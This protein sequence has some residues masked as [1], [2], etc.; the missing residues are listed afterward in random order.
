M[1]PII[2]G[3]TRERKARAA[4]MTAMLI[5]LASW[6]FYDA[7]IVYPRKN[8]EA[9]RDA[10]VPRPDILPRIDPAI[11]PSVKDSLQSGDLLSSVISRLGAAGWQHE[12]EYRWFGPNGSLRVIADGSTVGEVEW[13][14]GKNDT[15]AQVWI[16]SSM[17]VLGL[18]MLLR[19]IH[20]WRTRVV[21]DDGGLKIGGKSVIPLDAMTEIDPARYQEKGWI[22][23]AYADG[24][25]R[26]SVKLDDYVIEQFRPIVNAICEHK[27]W[28]DPLPPPPTDE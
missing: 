14:R 4:F 19:L 23:L 24:D 10:L 15:V 1:K 25:R 13:I 27:D 26:R 28:P 20:V 17:A 8:I 2:S 5:G 9:V 3:T 6:F 16:G 18:A 21:L 7:L 22:K 11:K 12:N